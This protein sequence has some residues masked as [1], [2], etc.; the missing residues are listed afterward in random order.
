MIRNCQQ[1]FDLTCIYIIYKF[2][3]M[4]FSDT[5]SENYKII[6]M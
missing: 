1:G 4:L 6:K 5:F 2:D 3:K